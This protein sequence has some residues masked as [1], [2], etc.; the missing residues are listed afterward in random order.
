M[1]TTNTDTDTPRHN[2]FALGLMT[3][4][5]VGA[6]LMLWLAPRAAAE[7]RSR[8]KGAVKALRTAATEQVDDATTSLSAIATELTTKGQT[9]K[10]GVADSVARGAHEVAREAQVVEKFARAASGTHR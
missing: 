5:C 4:T 10:N 8:A 2:G 3:G 1:T 9:L 7:L 6:G